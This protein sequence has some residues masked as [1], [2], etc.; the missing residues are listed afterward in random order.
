MITT[1]HKKYRKKHVFVWHK[2]R[3]RPV[4]QGQL[5]VF[6]SRL[7]ADGK[8]VNSILRKYAS[9]SVWHDIRSIG[10]YAILSRYCDGIKS[11]D[12]TCLRV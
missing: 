5:A 7:E 11:S 6:T 4:R 3:G 1:P 12:A 8:A 2:D 9:H 10:R